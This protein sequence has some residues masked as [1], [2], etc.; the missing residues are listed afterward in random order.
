MKKTPSKRFKL[1][2]DDGKEILQVI[3]W[4]LLSALVVVLLDVVQA[5]EFPAQYVFVVPIA[6]TLLVAA[7]KWVQEKRA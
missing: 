1:N 6:N 7:K 5:I 2:T 4:T 3:G